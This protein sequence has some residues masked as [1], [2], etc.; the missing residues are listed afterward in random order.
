MTKGEKIAKRIKRRL[1]GE[2][3]SVMLEFAFVA[4]LVVMTTVFAADFTRI[5]RTE[6]QLEIASR[7]MADVESHMANYYGKDKSPS[8]IAK[9]IGKHYLVDIA[10]VSANIGDAYVKGDCEVVPNPVS[11]AINEVNKF[12]KGETFDTKE[13]SSFMKYFV[14]LLGKILGSIANFVTFRTIN[15]LTD[16][17]PHDKEVKISTATYIP[18]ILPAACYKMFSLPVRSGD[19]I[20]VAQ[21]TA[22]LDSSSQ[23]A[24][25]WSYKI[26]LKKRHRVYCYMPVIDSVPIPPE[27]YIRV[28][29]SWCAKQPFLKGLTK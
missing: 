8:T 4:P 11:V 15:Y 27:T 7:L 23:A 18:T 25:A 13:D 16:V 17:V 10:E 2:H 5:L 9:R 6:Q 28:F 29:K 14:N 21:F 1:F 3:A 22:D 20:G 12:L 24:T 26:N 19:K